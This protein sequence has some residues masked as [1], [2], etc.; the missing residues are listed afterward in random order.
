MSYLW[1]S[2]VF[3][4]AKLVQ[5]NCKII[6]SDKRKF[7]VTRAVDSGLR[8]FLKMAGRSSCHP[9]TNPSVVNLF[10]QPKSR[11]GHLEAEIEMAP[12]LPFQ[13]RVKALMVY[14][15]W[16]DALTSEFWCKISTGS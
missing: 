8:S 15:L 3:S 6:A 7:R 10:G 16:G 1:G 4:E 11:V 5:I 13:V 12:L 14:F 2:T 9:V